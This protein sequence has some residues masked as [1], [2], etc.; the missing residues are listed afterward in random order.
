M[1]KSETVLNDK[2]H[3]ANCLIDLLINEGNLKN[4]AHLSR[5]IGTNAPYIS[6]VR[7]GTLPIT[8]TFLV[9]A[10]LAF[11]LEIRDMMAVAGLPTKKRAS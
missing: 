11:G 3:Y 8:Y 1:K 4:D 6:K 7:S 5:E 9:K 10:H 2:K